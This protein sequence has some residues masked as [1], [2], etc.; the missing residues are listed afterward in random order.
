MAISSVSQDTGL[1]NGEL[2][3]EESLTLLNTALVGES[4]FMLFSI[5]ATGAALG[6]Y[7]SISPMPLFLSGVAL[8]IA[9]CCAR[10]FNDPY[11]EDPAK[12]EQYRAEIS[13]IGLE[14]FI[15]KHGWEKLERYG[16]C[17][18]GSS[19]LI[20]K[21]AYTKAFFES[22]RPVDSPLI[23]RG[24]E[25]D[26]FL[27]ESFEHLADLLLDHVSALI[28]DGRLWSVLECGV[29]AGRKTRLVE[30]LSKYLRQADGY[31]ILAIWTRL[32]GQ[33]LVPKAFPLSAWA[34]RNC[35]MVDL[36]EKD[37]KE[38]K[39][40]LRADY[41]AARAQLKE[42]A[43]QARGK[44]LSQKEPGHHALRQISDQLQEDCC[45]LESDYMHNLEKITEEEKRLRMVVNGEFEAE[46]RAFNLYFTFDTC[47][48]EE[49]I[50]MF[51]VGTIEK[52]Q[53][54][55]GFPSI[56]E[57]SQKF[58]SEIDPPLWICLEKGWLNR[59]A[60]ER[61]E[62]LILCASAN[63]WDIAEQPAAVR[64]LDLG[65]FQDRA[66]LLER[67]GQI[68]PLRDPIRLL[69]CYH[70]LHQR[71]LVP[72]Q[73][74]GYAWLESLGPQFEARR[75]YF[76]GSADD[77]F[78]KMQQEHWHREVLE[79]IYDVEDPT[80]FQNDQ[81]E[82]SLQEFVLCYGW[83]CIAQLC[84]EVF[85]ERFFSEY[86][87]AQEQ[88]KTGLLW[89]LA[90]AY[91]FS[92]TQKKAIES[93]LLENV[94]VALDL[95]DVQQALD[96]G[97]FPERSTLVEAIDALDPKE[98]RALLVQIWPWIKGNGF[99][100]DLLRQIAPW[101]DCAAQGIL[102]EPS[103]ARAY[104]AYIAECD[105]KHQSLMQ[106]AEHY[107]AAPFVKRVMQESALIDRWEREDALWSFDR[108]NWILFEKGLLSEAHVHRWMHAWIVRHQTFREKILSP[109]FAKAF[110]LSLFSEDDLK[111]VAR[112]FHHPS[113][114]FSAAELISALDWIA[115]LQIT[116][117][118]EEKLLYNWAK[119]HRA[120]Q[121]PA[122]LERA[123]AAYKKQIGWSAHSGFGFDS[124]SKRINNADSERLLH[125]VFHRRS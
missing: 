37:I 66:P 52:S 23:W 87:S 47:R 84:L 11:Y 119:D 124:E 122:L 62:K 81:M 44:I 97:L 108:W 109:D 39:A 56:S 28:A 71:D 16:F 46:K 19:P 72:K 17:F 98:Y 117:S 18:A 99:V 53:R 77:P 86:P 75:E 49:L 111:E 8:P 15:E 73:W 13:R 70:T 89:P 27:E 6:L 41:L 85:A 25:R 55:F 30:G 2:E 31:D 107:G 29:F 123:F 42:V 24:F 3:R 96:M 101:F 112:S 40:Q 10:I 106:W 67:L 103:F 12:R 92:E 48:L 26:L 104:Q 95:G 1:L 4:L 93:A 33:G 9:A 57:L 90:A 58:M 35:T 32:D 5:M 22:P 110:R 69:R 125:K 114:F 43:E 51:G 45:L 80:T 38:Q 115:V 54:T 63:P 60:Q 14:A 91:P 50:T 100:G 94:A 88:L 118:A 83:D 79:K 21:E 102:D 74:K 113:T 78:L 82:M 64:A 116:F 59:P 68:D 120:W 65:L 34:Q 7:F 61:A 105:W 121:D 20:T 76:E 36:F